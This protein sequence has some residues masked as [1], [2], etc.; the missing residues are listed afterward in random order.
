MSSSS[1]S[2]L[3]NL[4]NL[5]LRA[6]PTEEIVEYEDEK[7]LRERT[8]FYSVIK[9][10]EDGDK[11]KPGCSIC[12]EPF[13][14]GRDVE[15][16]HCGHTYHI[17]CLRKALIDRP[18]RLC[19][20]C[21]D[22]LNAQEL[23]EIELGAAPAGGGS[24]NDDTEVSDDDELLLEPPPSPSPAHWRVF[25]MGP[26]NY[27]NG[28]PGYPAWPDDAVQIGRVARDLIRG[29][30]ND[31]DTGAG[32]GPEW[33]AARP[34]A[35]KLKHVFDPDDLS[36][37]G[38]TLSSTADLAQYQALMDYAQ[39]EIVDWSERL[40]E[41]LPVGIG[42]I[43]RTNVQVHRALTTWLYNNVF[44]IFASYNDDPTNPPL[45]AEPYWRGYRRGRGAATDDGLRPLASPPSKLQ[46]WGEVARTRWRD[47]S[48]GRNS[49]GV[50]YAGGV[51]SYRAP[52]PIFY[53]LHA[54]NAMSDHTR[55]IREQTGYFL[56]KAM[57]LGGEDAELAG[58]RQAAHWLLGL[59]RSSNWLNVTT[60]D[61]AARMPL[62]GQLVQL[63]G[64][65]V[66]FADAALIPAYPPTQLD[67]DQHEMKVLAKPAIEWL[68][69]NVW[70]IHQNYDHRGGVWEPSYVRYTPGR[71]RLLSGPY[72]DG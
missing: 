65:A 2:N 30:V 3:P 33:A 56:R 44:H 55:E 18:E 49:V 70:V 10:D 12:L 66:E 43:A 8:R 67:A 39:Q 54:A 38:A 15:M 11:E 20:I 68:H 71:I 46:Q 1:S 4:S 48:R 32:T 28:W 64:I 40:Y 24:D 61:E 21:K 19:P 17:N 36:P 27:E 42:G 5:A 52:I 47:V 14:S 9:D 63:M 23:G 50:D 51:F 45:V 34:A 53:D 7:A 58:V 31:S 37:V 26:V 22:P 25:P 69:D 62:A 35:Y 16:L 13:V 29:I 60:G 6:Q 72:I 57:L 41:E 59:N